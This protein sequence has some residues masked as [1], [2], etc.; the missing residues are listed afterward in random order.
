MAKNGIF[1]I[2]F[3][4]IFL[5]ISSITAILWYSK[6][7]FLRS[8]SRRHIGGEHFF[9]TLWSIVHDWGWP[10]N[11]PFWTKN[12]QTW[13]ACQRFKR[14][15]KDSKWST[16]VYLTIWDPFWAHLLSNQH[17]SLE[18]ISLWRR[19]GRRCFWGFV[20]KGSFKQ[21]LESWSRSKPGVYSSLL[22]AIAGQLPLEPAKWH[23]CP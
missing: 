23:D 5:I 20:L 2:E 4:P 15:Q 9:F 6:P 18:W 8:T 3:W 22:L 17:S 21:I 10:K 13:Q 16:Q 7:V 19:F 12:S 1:F 14:V 11:D